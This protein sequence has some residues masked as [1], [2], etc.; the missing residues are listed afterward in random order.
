[1]T[2][3]LLSIVV[4]IIGRVISL[5]FS[6][7]AVGRHEEFRN[8]TKSRGRRRGSFRERMA[9][10]RNSSSTQ[11]RYLIA[12]HGR[13]WER[14]FSAEVGAA[15][16]TVN[17]H[18]AVGPFEVPPH[19]SHSIAMSLRMFSASYS[20]HERRHFRAAGALRKWRNEAQGSVIT[21]DARDRQTE[22]NDGRSSLSVASR[23]IRGN[24][25]SRSATSLTTGP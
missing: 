6:K 4:A 18:C 21:P 16:S 5:A 12:H 7:R 22:F 3:Q 19:I 8:K 1:M 10:T 20:T 11:S 25:S 13:S 2:D 14:K 17:V 15:C 9:P 23:E 24:N